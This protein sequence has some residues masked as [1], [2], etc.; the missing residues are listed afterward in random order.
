MN[1]FDQNKIEPLRLFLEDEENIFEDVKFLSIYPNKGKL[2]IKFFDN[3]CKTYKI[4][5]MK[6]RDFVLIAILI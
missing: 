3:K 5:K 4:K 1:N 2:L 6:I